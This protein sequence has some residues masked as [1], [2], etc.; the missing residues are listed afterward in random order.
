MGTNGDTGV[1]LRKIDDILRDAEAQMDVM[2]AQTV[3]DRL[4]SGVSTPDFTR[5]KE[6][7]EFGF[8][9]QEYNKLHA[10]ALV[11]AC[12]NQ[13][14]TNHAD[15]SVYAADKSYLWDIE[16]TGLFSKPATKT[17]KGYEDFSPYP[18]WRDPSNPKML[19]VD[20]DQPRKNPEPYAM[21]KR[22]VEIYIRDKYPPYWL[23]IYDN[24]HGVQHPNLKHL[25]NLIQGILHARVQR[26]RLPSNLR[27]VWAFDSA[28]VVRA[29]PRAKASGPW[30]NRAVGTL[31]G[32]SRKILAG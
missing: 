26:G 20:I 3:V 28:G 25:A 19:H 32:S 27:Q 31:I 11:W 17:P 9:V 6:E 24:E 15:F 8:F 7:W 12:R 30:R 5:L 14:G 4:Y 29:W 2:G 22:V 10:P 13:P 16:V 21:L 1:A 18:V 23:V